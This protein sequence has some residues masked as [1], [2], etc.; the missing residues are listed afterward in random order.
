[1]ANKVNCRNFH[2]DILDEEEES[3]DAEPTDDA[4]RTSS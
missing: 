4:E 3:R 1:M 2:V